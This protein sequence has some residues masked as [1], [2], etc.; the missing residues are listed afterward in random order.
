[1]RGAVLCAEYGS[2]LAL[3]A[4]VET[5][6]PALGHRRRLVE[7]FDYATVLRILPSPGR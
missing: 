1:L 7:R 2:V 6:D 5:A 3:V 4:Q